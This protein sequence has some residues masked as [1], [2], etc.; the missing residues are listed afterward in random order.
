MYL[1]N[2]FTEIVEASR[3]TTNKILDLMMIEGDTN[4]VDENLIG[5]K[6]VSATPS[7]LEIFLEFDEPIEVSQ[8]S[9]P[10]KLL[11]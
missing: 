8:G 9:L 11:I 7:K 5:W 10:D 1:P 4:N 3:N 6:L 2:D